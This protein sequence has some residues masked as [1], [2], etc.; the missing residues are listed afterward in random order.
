MG[1]EARVIFQIKPRPSGELTLAFTRSLVRN[2]QRLKPVLLLAKGLPR[3]RAN[4]PR[5]TGDRPLAARRGVGLRIV[6]VQMTA[7]PGGKERVA[8]LAN[9]GVKARA[10]RQRSAGCARHRHGD[11]ED[12]RTTRPYGWRLAGIGARLVG[13][14]VR[15]P[16]T[17]PRNSP[18]STLTS[19]LQYSSFALKISRA[20]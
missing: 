8:H 7:G 18:K 20:A 11:H 2:G 9:G 17:T 10:I 19:R 15:L 3:L 4:G 5:D 16:F 6:V 13:A 1:P 12:R 14:I